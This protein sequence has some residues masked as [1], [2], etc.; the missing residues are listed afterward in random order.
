MAA[1]VAGNMAQEHSLKGNCS[2][3][4]CWRDPKRSLFNRYHTQVNSDNSGA[5]ALLYIMN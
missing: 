5:L 1:S 4:L 3:L 2:E